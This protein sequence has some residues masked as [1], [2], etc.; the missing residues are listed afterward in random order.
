MSHIASQCEQKI[1]HFVLHQSQRTNAWRTELVSGL[2]L[3]VCGYASSVSSAN[4][5]QFLMGSD[6]CTPM[7]SQVRSKAD[8]AKHAHAHPRSNCFYSRAN[9]AQIKDSVATFLVP[10][11]DGA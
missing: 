2:R 3:Y 4:N 7:H 11:I 8:C 9:Q 10:S 5:V 6:F 1:L